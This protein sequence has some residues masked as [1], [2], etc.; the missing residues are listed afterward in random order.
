MNFF[1][2]T[3]STTVANILTFLLYQAVVNTGWFKG[4]RIKLTQL[5]G[6]IDPPAEKKYGE[7]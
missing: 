6:K 3:L 4:I 2:Q 7:T 5:L 1:M